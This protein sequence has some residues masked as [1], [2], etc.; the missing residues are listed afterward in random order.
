M[1]KYRLSEELGNIDEAFLEEVFE[2]QSKKRSIRMSKKKIVSIVIAAALVVSIGVTAVAASW[3]SLNQLSDYFA[4]NKEDFRVPDEVP[5]IEDPEIYAKEVAPIV[6][7]TESGAEKA[8]SVTSEVKAYTP[9]APGTAQVASVSATKRSI[10]MMIEFNAEGLDI[11]AEL[12]EDA[13]WDAEYDF[14]WANTNFGWSGGRVVDISREGNI[15]TY[16][17]SWNHLYDLPDDELVITL[18]R[19]GYIT[20]D[21]DFNTLRDIEV[22][23]RLPI[24]EIDFMETIT[25]K[26]T[27]ELMGATYTAEISA[28]DFSVCTDIEELVANGLSDEIGYEFS[29]EMQDYLYKA[30][31]EF[32]FTDGTVYSRQLGTYGKDVS[33]LI[34]SYGALRDPE[35]E[36][37]TM[38]YSFE[39]PLDISKIDYVLFNGQRFDFSSAE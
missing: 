21:K 4:W 33:Y 18:Q 38:I 10:F 20:A 7:T 8:V 24:D 35:E 1:K 12:P 9:P 15:F 27:A 13:K 11:P 31:I 26:N 16:L 3:S 2:Y 22:E 28:Y 6:T 14:D 36:T 30:D 25:A 5:I 39:V 23:V 34:T 29:D 17:Y 37:S 32:H 19:F